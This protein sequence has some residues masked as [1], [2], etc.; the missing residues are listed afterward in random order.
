MSETGHIL[1]PDTQAVLLLCG[2]FAVK[3]N[4][5]VKP[6]TITQYNR[7][8]TWLR[9]QQ[10]RPSV[11]LGEKGI[12]LLRQSIDRPKEAEEALLLLE[13]GVAMALTIENW[14]NQGIWVLS[15]S[16]MDY[17]KRFK[18]RLKQNSPAI[19][20]GRASCRERV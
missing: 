20:I 2:N 17:P 3:S 16:D 15:R 19:Q 5:G 13:R 18:D 1:S 8:A 7:I 12:G 14:A 6:L 4:S 9:D 11:L 10:L